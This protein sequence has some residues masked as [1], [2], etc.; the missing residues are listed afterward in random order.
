MTTSCGRG[1]VVVIW[2]S[3]QAICGV[4]QSILSAPQRSCGA[5]RDFTLFSEET[6]LKRIHLST[7]RLYRGGGRQLIGKECNPSLHLLFYALNSKAW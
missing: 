4:C 6:P 1:L 3:N 2:A 7:S 5:F